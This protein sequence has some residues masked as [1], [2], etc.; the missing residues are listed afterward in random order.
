M[1][2][3]ER[4]RDGRRGAVERYPDVARYWLGRRERHVQPREQ[5]VVHPAGLP[6]RHRV[7]GWTVLVPVMHR[8]I[9]ARLHLVRAL[10]H[11]RAPCV[12]QIADRERRRD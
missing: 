11:G 3:C 4:R 2:R 9:G 8:A 7:G 6:R 5:L 1:G 12:R 10:V